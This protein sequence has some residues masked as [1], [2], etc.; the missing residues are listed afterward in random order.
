LSAPAIAVAL[1]F[2]PTGTRS[3]QADATTDSA[4]IAKVMAGAPSA[5]VRG[6]KIVTTDGKRTLQQGTNGFT[7]GLSAKGPVCAD[8][9][10]LLWM[11]AV[12]THG[13]PPSVV[14]FAYTLGG[15]SGSS[16]TDPYAADPT[17]MNHW[18]KTGPNVMIFGP[19]IKTMGY[20]MSPDADPSKPY[21]MW[22]S[23][24]YAHLMVP[25][26]LQPR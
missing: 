23:T 7:C 3:Q 14:G 15:D 26:T 8:R 6:A 5:V 9:N 2:A 24:P 10:A 12:A 16:N 17:A 1:S 19:T 25:V 18:M 11:R 4:Y 13:A 21:V 22:E 20:P